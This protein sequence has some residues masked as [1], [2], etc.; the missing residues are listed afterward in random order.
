MNSQ[1]LALVSTPKRLFH[2]FRFLCIGLLLIALPIAEAD[3]QEDIEKASRGAEKFI[4]D[5]LSATHGSY[6]AVLDWVNQRD[7]VYPIFKERL[8]KLY[9]DALKADP[10]G[11]YGA[12]AILAGVDEV[13]TRYRTVD[14]FYGRAHITITLQAVSPAGCNHQVRVVMMQADD[15]KWKVQSCGDV[16]M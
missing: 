12:D 4:T 9:L 5:Y 15:G 13:G 8:F 6:L 2:G 11:G 16:P 10:E 14:T 7:D 3:D 1:R